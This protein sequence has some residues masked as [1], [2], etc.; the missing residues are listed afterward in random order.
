MPDI[1][2]PL[3]PDTKNTTI[4]CWCSN[5]ASDGQPWQEHVADRP[6][7]EKYTC[8]RCGHVDKVKGSPDVLVTQR[9]ALVKSS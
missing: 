7:P 4:R 6:L 5:C 3:T 2:I 1:R 9:T 8:V